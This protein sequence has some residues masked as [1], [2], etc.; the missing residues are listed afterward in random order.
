MLASALSVPGM[1]LA[2]S[3]RNGYVWVPGG[4]PIASAG[5]RKAEAV[6]AA[7]PRKV[8]RERLD[9]RRKFITP[10]PALAPELPANFP[11]A[12]DPLGTWKLRSQGCFPP[13]RRSASQCRQPV[14]D[15]KL[16]ASLC[17]RHLRV[18]S[19]T[20]PSPQTG[21][22][23]VW[24]FPRTLNHHDQFDVRIIRSEE[25]TSELQSLRHL[26]CRL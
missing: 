21:L 24:E 26:V 22:R 19:V 10:A 9:I 3:F 13:V 5:R 17:N 23:M 7:P 15:D 25:H 16:I 18:R 2:N 8:L 4:I 11:F 20:V 6:S 12:D 1:S 14:T